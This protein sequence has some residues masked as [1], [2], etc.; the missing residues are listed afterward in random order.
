R[1]KYRPCSVTLRDGRRFEN[2]YVMAAQDYI[3][4]WGVW[5]EDDSGKR[6]V[7][8]EQ[9]LSLDESPNRLP[10]WAADKLYRAGESGMGYRVFSVRCRDGTVQAHI[11]GNAI[12]FISFPPG[13]S[14]A[15]IAEVFP[16]EGRNDPRALQAPD[17]FW[18][19][20]GSG[21]SDSKSWRWA[22]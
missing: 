16:H 20:H 7:P 22:G 6:S 1:I 19:L 10:A 14:A 15:D 3:S 9:V 17:Y 18:C 21:E 11:S 5:P 4:T 2:V 13:K 12:D 8:I